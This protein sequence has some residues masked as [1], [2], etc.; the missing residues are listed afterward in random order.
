MKKIKVS[1]YVNLNLGDDLF[2]KILFERY[3]DIKFYVDCPKKLFS[4]YKSNFPKIKFY[5]YHSIISKIR[6]FYTRKISNDYINL[7]IGGSIFQENENTKLI[8]IWLK[9]KNTY[10][11]GANFGPYFTD[12]YLEWYKAYFQSAEDVCFRDRYSYSLFKDL[13]N[14]RY[15]PDIVF[16]YKKINSENKRIS[17][18]KKIAV[19]VIN[20][21]NRKGLRA[22][23]KLYIKKMKEVIK[24]FSEKNYIILLMSFCKNEGDEEAIS[25]ILNGINNKVNIE[26]LFYQG[27]LE[28]TLQSINEADYV[29]ANRFHSLVLSW[30]MNKPAFPI[31]YSKK[32]KCVLE[33]MNYFGPSIEICNI[34]NLNPQEI[35]KFF[36]KNEI[37]DVNKEKLQAENHFY[38]LD[39]MI[40]QN[41]E[42]KK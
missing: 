30:C 17:K 42:R 13:P 33:D 3:K 22:Y 20:L 21:K 36:E 38:A 25:D 2:L 4:I 41:Q 1:G 29:I 6:N 23:H 39:K 18:R 34:E 24:F 31:I 14:V 10:I 28:D 5:R 12:G 37:M 16:S 35:L 27:K 9:D 19:S 15:A 32:T 11:L 8:K 26:L 40:N 7:K